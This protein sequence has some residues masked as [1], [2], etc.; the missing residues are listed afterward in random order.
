MEDES[1]SADWHNPGSQSF[2][3]RYSIIG[4]PTYP[5]WWK[6]RY[7]CPY[8]ALRTP[9][10]SL[11]NIVGPVIV[12]HIFTVISLYLVTYHST[13]FLTLSSRLS[14]CTALSIRVTALPL[15]ALAV[16]SIRSVQR[17]SFLCIPTGQELTWLW[18]AEEIL[19]LQ[20]NKW[21]GIAKVAQTMLIEH[22][23]HLGL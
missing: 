19:T 18:I 6:S 2:S 23:F 16:S 21:W 12:P 5:D 10:L 13:A 22:T 8:Y 15:S 9:T 14:R 17:W 1:E 4:S 3:K 7:A 11:Y 20:A